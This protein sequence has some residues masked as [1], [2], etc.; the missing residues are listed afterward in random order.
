MVQT[1]SA[2]GCSTLESL[3]GDNQEWLMSRMIEHAELNGFLGYV[4]IREESW[5]ES[6]RRLVRAFIDEAEYRRGCLA[7]RADEDFAM[8]PAVQFGRG[9][10]V[11]H[12]SRGVAPGFFLALLTHYRRGF[13]DLVAEMADPA[14]RA[15]LS[16]LVSAFFDRLVIGLGESWDEA[17]R[18]T[19]VQEMR[20][21][22]RQAT[23]EK[24]LYKTV[25]EGLN[26]QI[27]L[28]DEVGG[29]VTANHAVRHT[30][31]VPELG[32]PGDS[33]LTDG[34]SSHPVFPPLADQIHEFIASGRSH[35]ATEQALQTNQGERHF[36]VEFQHVADVGSKFAGTTLV[37]TDITVHRELED[38]SRRAQHQE[39][40]ATHDVLTG[41]PNRRSFEESLRAASARASR[42][43]RSA[44]LFL[45]I[46]DFKVCND[47]RGHTFGDEVLVRVGKAL[48]SELREQDA[49]AR[50]GGDEFGVVLEGA[51]RSD[52]V[53]VVARMRR[54]VGELA[55]ELSAV[56]SL[57]VG[58]AEIGGESDVET[59]LMEADRH[60][61]CDKSAKR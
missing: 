39:Y 36:L 25:L 55:R 6:I 56:L 51:S 34:L 37:L 16:A 35:R 2:A 19:L 21:H 59:L 4:S 14:E 60:M 48:A 40:L 53:P 18:D 61:Y 1:K 46:D 20:A 13:E 54:R 44:L 31:E 42:G 5:R 7:L 8:D 32:G 15:G 10:G 28:L 33:V 22:T 47:T 12:R 30:F 43:V 26:M 24:D 41:L 17:G 49:L 57:S 50:L 29:V 23:T 45:D 11:A 27:M 3:F 58:I 9:E 52:A 38:A